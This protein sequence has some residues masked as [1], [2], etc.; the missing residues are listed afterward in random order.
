MTVWPHFHIQH[1][2]VALPSVLTDIDYWTIAL[3][4]RTSGHLHDG[5][6]ELRE[7]PG[8]HD[9]MTVTAHRPIFL[10]LQFIF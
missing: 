8:V 1:T 4:T 7:Y 5:Y 6:R 3:R 9:C 10:V 2:V